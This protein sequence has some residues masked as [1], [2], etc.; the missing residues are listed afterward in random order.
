MKTKYIFMFFL[1]L[2]TCEG[3]AQKLNLYSGDFENA[4]RYNL[5]LAET[6]P[7][8]KETADT[9]TVLNLSGFGLTDIRDIVYFPN[10]QKLDLS[11]NRLRNVSP[12]IILRYLNWVN[13]SNNF[14]ESVDVLVFSISP[15][16]LVDATSNYIQDFELLKD[17]QQCLFT[18]IGIG[19][20]KPFYGVRKLYTD[21]DLL[22]SEKIINYNIWT[23]SEYDSVYVLY[24][25]EKELT[26]ANSLDH[27]IKSGFTDNSVY[28]SF[29]EQI[30][31]TAWFVASVTLEIEKDSTVIIPSFPA[32]CEILSV[33]SFNQSDIGYSRDS[34]LFKFSDNIAKDTVKVGFGRRVPDG[35]DN[36]KG[37]T[38]YFITCPVSSDA[39]LKELMVSDGTLS[40]EFDSETVAYTVTVPNEVASIDVSGTANHEAASVS[41]NVSGKTLEVGDNE[42]NITVTAED[43]TTTKT[44]TVTV[45]RVS[46]DATLSSLELSAGT[47]SFDANTTV[48]T[49]NVANS[50]TSID[51][52]GTANHE[53]AT[54]NGNVTN[55]TLDV[56]DNV[57]NITVTAEDG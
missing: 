1:L 16:L 39:T 46:N 22:T 30:F 25:N 32:S 19:L 31:D 47:L 27:Q 52:N 54:V 43:E 5:G 49:V 21:F 24:D 23:H 45:H 34:I 51:V 9:V 57:V 14:L 8:T 37:Y 42:V 56:G 38:Y 13:L 15:Q 26:V 29:D 6:A 10:I 55:K 41:G 18:I 50:I 36:V 3:V 4:V 40:P 12:L 48:Y 53:A 33:E 28:L 11:F 20:Q 2:L 44:Y 17:S 35:I 7:V